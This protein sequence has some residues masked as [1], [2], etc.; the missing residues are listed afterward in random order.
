[1]WKYYPWPSCKELVELI[2]FYCIIKNT[3]TA[4]MLFCQQLY[5]PL[6]YSHVNYMFFCDMKRCTNVKKWK[7][8]AVL[9]FSYKL[10]GLAAAIFLF[11]VQYVRVPMHSKFPDAFFHT[12]LEVLCFFSLNIYCQAQQNHILIF[13]LFFHTVAGHQTCPCYPTF[14]HHYIF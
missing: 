14:L 5:F 2:M 9:S 10:K 11:H 12:D 7:V 8:N 3:T 1:M 6:T 13:C 4:V